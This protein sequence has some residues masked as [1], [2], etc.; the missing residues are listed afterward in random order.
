MNSIGV[1]KSISKEQGIG[2]SVAE[3]ME[4]VSFL[5]NAGLTEVEHKFKLLLNSATAPVDKI[6]AYTFD[7]GGKR[8]R[9]S[10]CLIS[11]HIS[12]KSITQPA[13]FPVDLAVVCEMLHNATL[14]HDDV[15]DEGDSRRGKPAARKVWSN[16]LSVL[17]GDY[18]LMK[19]VELMSGFDPLYMSL[20]VNTLKSLVEGEIIQ[21]QLREKIDTTAEDYYRIVKGKTSSLFKFATCSGAKWG[22][23][24]DAECDAMGEFGENIGIAFQLIDDVLDFSSDPEQLGKD[25]L[26]DIGQGKATLPL[27]EAALL[28]SEVKTLLL[29]LIDGAEPAKSAKQISAIVNSSGALEKVRMSAKEYTQKSIDALNSINNPN[30]QIVT[31]LKKLSNALLHRSR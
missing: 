6:T 30:I 10:L 14:L 3:A 2:G 16:A 18:M 9:P 21:L 24:S 8:I 4:D 13:E 11:S 22:G 31:I 26:A 19:C 1:L 28:N 20:F 5:L 7:A 15:I 29:E 27:I 25:M 23:L 12:F 17:G